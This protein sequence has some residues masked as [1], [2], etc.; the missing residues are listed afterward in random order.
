MR[1]HSPRGA[2]CTRSVRRAESAVKREGMC[3]GSRIQLPGIVRALAGCRQPERR[4]PGRRHG[5]ARTAGSPRRHLRNDGSAPRHSPAA[6]AQVHET[7]HTP[8]PPSPRR[9]SSCSSCGEF[10]GSRGRTARLSGSDS[11]WASTARDGARPCGTLRDSCD[12][13]HRPP[14][15]PWERGPRHRSPRGAKGAPRSPGR[16]E[17]RSNANVRLAARRAADERIDRGG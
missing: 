10:I 8:G 6:D 2:D 11:Q 16:D 14:P 1:P 12:P 9:R 5:T 15:W 13:S 4:F 7:P 17:G 3:C